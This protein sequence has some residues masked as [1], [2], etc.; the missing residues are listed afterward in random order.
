M[1]NDNPLEE[2]VL[3]YREGFSIREISEVLECSEGTVKSRLFYTCRKLAKK[4]HEFGNDDVGRQP[5]VGNNR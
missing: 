3:R 2:F 1:S 4:L 5:K